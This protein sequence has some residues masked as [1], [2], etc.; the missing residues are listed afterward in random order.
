MRSRTPWGVALLLLGLALG[1]LTGC[2][3]DSDDEP[4]SPSPTSTKSSPTETEPTE[5]PS[6]TVTPA[7]GP[8]I[9]AAYRDK[10]VLRVRLPEEADWRLQPGGDNASTNNAAGD[11]V[12]V[13]VAAILTVPGKDLDFYADLTVDGGKNIV[14][15]HLKRVQD[16]EVGGVPGYVAEGTGDKFSYVF[17]AVHQ[18]AHVTISFRFRGDDAEAREWIESVLA[19]AEW[20]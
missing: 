8:E 15:P 13:A 12:D 16:R 14:Y 10:P 11:F 18:D 4:G 1:Q 5:P 20:L 2:S 17:G 9:T 6:P 19:S 3:T 7:T